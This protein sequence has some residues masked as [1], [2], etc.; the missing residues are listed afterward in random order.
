VVLDALRRSV[1]WHRGADAGRNA[2]LN[3]CRAV[4]WTVDRTWL[5]KP[6]AGRWWLSRRDEPIVAAALADARL[7]PPA[8]E[9]FL[10]RAETQLT[11]P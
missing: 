6:A 9:D 5:A 2:V 1:A 4:R 11:T 10:T 7:S 3:A 8:V